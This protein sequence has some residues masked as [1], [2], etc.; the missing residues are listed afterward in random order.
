M[1]RLLLAA[2]G[3]L[4]MTPAAVASANLDCS[5][6]DKNVAELSIEA[7][8]SRDGKYL[9]NMRGELQLASG[10]KVEFDKS[11]VKSYRWGKNVAFVI[12][13]QTPQ[14]P[15]EIRIYAKP[16]DEIDFEGTYLVTAGKTRTGGK[17]ACSGG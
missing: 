14:G 10:L 7:I 13:K 1:K 16:K 4:A 5:A 6:K 11:N 9:D 8:T 15:V 17:V 2:A 12:A 3:F